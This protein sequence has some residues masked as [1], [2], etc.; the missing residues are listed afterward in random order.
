MR[1]DILFDFILILLSLLAELPREASLFVGSKCHL[2]ISAIVLALSLYVAA[3]ETLVIRLP[4]KQYP[5]NLFCL[6][7]QGRM[8]RE[9]F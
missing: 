6:E 1:S 7:Q 2:N 8:R 9:T 4:A 3:G 5:L